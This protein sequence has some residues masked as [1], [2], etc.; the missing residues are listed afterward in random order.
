MI[1][2]KMRELLVRIMALVADKD[3]SDD[4]FDIEMTKWQDE[5]NKIIAIIAPLPTIADD[6]EHMPQYLHV[7]APALV[8]DEL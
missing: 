6:F 8:P 2:Q 7:G 4:D 5:V 1:N 3:L